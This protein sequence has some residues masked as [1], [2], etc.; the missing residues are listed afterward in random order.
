M[1]IHISVAWYIDLKCE[2]DVTSQ[3]NAAAIFRSLRCTTRSLLFLNYPSAIASLSVS[4][5][6][7]DS[8]TTNT[9]TIMAGWVGYTITVKPW[10]RCRLT[11]IHTSS[12]LQTV[13]YYGTQPAVQAIADLGNFLATDS[14]FDDLRDPFTRS[15]SVIS[16][17]HS[18]NAVMTNDARVDPG[19][20]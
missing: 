9:N 18:V 2:L 15:P 11:V 8:S 4:P 6:G 3:A 17:D 13:H 12:T 16:C 1:S 14:S 7:A 5:A 10:G 19:A 20:D